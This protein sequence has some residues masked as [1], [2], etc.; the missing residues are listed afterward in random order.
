[1]GDAGVKLD[2]GSPPV[3]FQREQDLSVFETAWQWRKIRA[4]VI[5]ST[6]TVWVF[7]VDQQA[8]EPLWVVEVRARTDSP[9]MR[10]L[11]RMVI[12]SSRWSWRCRPFAPPNRAAPMPSERRRENRRTNCPNRRE[13]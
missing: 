12:A 5:D 4:K 11:A 3:V 2:V 1:M 9:L 8:R 6:G 13:R 7:R 10:R